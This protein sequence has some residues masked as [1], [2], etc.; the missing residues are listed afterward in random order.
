MRARRPRRN[1]LFR[2]RLHSLS[3]ALGLP[4]GFPV[5]RFS[6]GVSRA[7]LHF[8]RTTTLT[9]LRRRPGRRFSTDRVAFGG[10][11][12]TSAGSLITGLSPPTAVVALR[13]R[14]LRRWRRL[15]T[16]PRR[17]EASSERRAA[18]LI[19]PNF[20]EILCAAEERIRFLFITRS[21]TLYSTS[22][23]CAL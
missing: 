17:R 6:F 21:P 4:R 18:P 10:A 15:M 14:H 13:C 20:A 1:T 22:L 5:P 3:G 11:P 19:S 7:F 16:P 23:R 8:T 2:R 9:V 12:P